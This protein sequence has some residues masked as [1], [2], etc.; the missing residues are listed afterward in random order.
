MAAHRN[1]IYNILLPKQNKKDINDIPEDLR[2]ELKISL[3]EH[4]FEYLD[5]A[6]EKEVDT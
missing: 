4:I 2:K 3:C 1:G 6:L 5:Y